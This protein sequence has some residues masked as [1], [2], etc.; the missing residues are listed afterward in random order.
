MLQPVFIEKLVNT[1]LSKIFLAFMESLSL[2]TMFTKTKHYTTSW[3]VKC[4]KTFRFHLFNIY[5]N[6]V[7]HPY[8]GPYRGLLPKVSLLKF[9]MNIISPSMLY[10][11]PI[12]SFL[13]WPSI[14]NLV[15]MIIAAPHYAIYPLL[16]H[17]SLVLIL[18]E[19]I[20]SDITYEIKSLIF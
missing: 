1:Q 17:V 2:I 13:S 6:I 11:L 5:F 20:S 15:K 3:T 7:S 8:L 16:L 12:S 10:I 14:Y 9:S 18:A 4:S 19:L